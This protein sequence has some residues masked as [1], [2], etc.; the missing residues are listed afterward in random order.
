MSS[1]QNTRQRRHYHLFWMVKKCNPW[2]WD[3]QVVP[4]HR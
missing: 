3:W 4:E 2:G 1:F